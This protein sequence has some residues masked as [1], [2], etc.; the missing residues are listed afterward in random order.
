MRTTSHKQYKPKSQ[1]DDETRHEIKIQIKNL[2]KSFKM[3]VIYFIVVLSIYIVLVFLFF[4]IEHCY[5]P[6]IPTKTPK[7]KLWQLCQHLEKNL[8][9][10]IHNDT[11]LSPLCKNH[12]EPYR[13]S[14]QLTT[15]NF[16]KYFD[17]VASISF[18]L[19]W[20]EV[21]PYS[22][23]G[24]IVTMIITLPFIAISMPV[25][26]YTGEMITSVTRI[27]VVIIR[28]KF[29]RNFSQK[30][31]T[32]E[33]LVS[34]MFM[35][36]VVWL[37]LAAIDYSIYVDENK[38]FFDSMYYSMMTIS[39]VGFGDFYWS[40]EDCFNKGFHYLLLSSFCFLFSMGTFAS[41]LT[42]VNK[43][44][45]DLTTKKPNFLRKVRKMTEGRTRNEG[46][47]NSPDNEGTKN[48]PKILREMNNAYI[49]HIY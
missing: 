8:T 44:I 49:N 15:T 42:Q 48:S 5:D 25:Y 30:Y 26:I 1:E 2:K 47:I 19:G 4:Y 6:V 45:C 23:T 29:Q 14:C 7:H 20:G 22:D 3:F 34:Q 13:I 12:R 31:L 41:T 32:L 28:R 43:L 27:A 10:D 17:Y 37:S 35:T 40:S 36:I 38:R 39:T 9:M 16:F 18:T 11:V 24:K 33:T 21:V 46:T